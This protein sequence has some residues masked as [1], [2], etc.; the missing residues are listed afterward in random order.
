MVRICFWVVSRISSLSRSSFL[1]LSRISFRLF[2]LFGTLVGCRI[3]RGGIL[4]Y[5]QEQIMRGRGVSTRLVLSRVLSI[6][7]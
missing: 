3:W 7:L 1:I 5:P 4:Q 6:F 2:N